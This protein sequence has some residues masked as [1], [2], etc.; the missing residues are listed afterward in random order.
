MDVAHRTYLVFTKGGPEHTEFT[1]NNFERLKKLFGKETRKSFLLTGNSF[2]INT[3]QQNGQDDVVLAGIQFKRTEH[4]AWINCV[5]T[6]NIRGT[7]A[8]FGG[9]PRLYKDDDTPFTGMGLAFL[10]LRAVQLHLCFHGMV[11]HLFV[12]AENGTDF[13]KFLENRG[14]SKI[15][16]H[17]PPDDPSYFNPDEYQSLKKT[18]ET[19]KPLEESIVRRPGHDVFVAYNKIVHYKPN[20]GWPRKMKPTKRWNNDDT[21]FYFPF[22]ASGDYIDQCA[23]GLCFLGSQFFNYGDHQGI[24]E[25]SRFNKV[26]QSSI[27]TGAKYRVVAGKQFGDSNGW[28]TSEHIQFMAN[29]IFRDYGNATVQQ[30]QFVPV[31]V[32]AALSYVFDGEGNDDTVGRILHN[33]CSVYWRHLQCFMLFL[34][35]NPNG[36]HWVLNVA[37]N[38][39]QLLRFIS[40]YDTTTG[41]S[42]INSSNAKGEEYYG[43]FHVDPLEIETALPKSGHLIFLLNYMSYY[44]DIYHT[45][46]NKTVPELRRNYIWLRGSVGPYGTLVR[47]VRRHDDC[48]KRCNLPLL[49]THTPSFPVQNDS[50]N[51]GVYVFVTIIDLV[52]T[53]W[54]VKWLLTDLYEESEDR[55]K[56]LWFNSVAEGLP[57]TV[58]EKYGIG[59]TFRGNETEEDTKSMYTRIATYMRMEVAVLMERLHCVYFDAFSEHQL[60]TESNILGVIPRDYQENLK[61]DKLVEHAL[62][63]LEFENRLPSDCDKVWV[64]ERREPFENYMIR[65]GPKISYQRHCCRTSRFR[66]WLTVIAVTAF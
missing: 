2:T 25:G 50:Y 38:P 12:E 16:D 37:V 40:N 9:T 20:L 13:H 39:G 66:N 60:K 41:G 59:K 35:E 30:F 46:E 22:A 17:V 57:I 29:L 3:F 10:L 21:L 56:K 7:A 62:S 63:Q 4:G 32:C 24:T 51:C 15:T 1:T 58:P 18:F 49:K 8:I 53:Q 42:K 5:A 45:T 48:I 52:L 65:K 61:S 44:R 6:T 19:M 64:K 54:N 26:I 27:I 47:K 33:Y 34:A 55:A 43:W 31:E 14:F 36:N 23:K 11:P 28:L